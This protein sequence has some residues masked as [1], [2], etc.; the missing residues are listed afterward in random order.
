MLKWNIHTRICIRCRIELSIQ[1]RCGSGTRSRWLRDIPAPQK[2]C[3][4]ASTR[5]AT[6]RRR[7][8]ARG[9]RQCGA[10]APDPV[11]KGS[12]VP[13]GIPGPRP[14]EGSERTRHR[15][16]D[17]RAR[18]RASCPFRV[19]PPASLQ[20]ACPA[21]RSTGLPQLPSVRA[22]TITRASRRLQAP[23]RCLP[24][25][26]CLALLSLRKNVPTT[27]AAT[28]D[29]R[30]K[31][32]A[33]ASHQLKP[34]APPRAHRVPSLSDVSGGGAAEE[35]PCDGRLEDLRPKL[36]GHLHDHDAAAADRL[37][38]PQP[39][40][41][42]PPA[43]PLPLPTAPQ[44]EPPAAR[45]WN[46]RDRKR[47]PSARAAEAAAAS[48]SPATSPRDPASEKAL[49]DE[50]ASFAVALTAEEVEEDIYALTGARP[51]RRPRK[52]PRVVQR[53][54]DVRPNSPYYPA[55]FASS[56][57]FLSKTKINF[58]FVSTRYVSLSL[59]A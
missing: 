29:P 6:G 58:V 53:Q 8:R 54:L 47:R 30:A 31:P 38:L 34:W 13:A 15:H 20:R 52:R 16:T 11:Q 22:H 41:P 21:P 18:A 40:S 9:T 51:R 2:C 5:Q 59:S 23:L 4:V 37:L 19:Y 28:A 24:L 7:A 56:I 43:A 10:G 44:Q 27:M 25:S 49:S 50:R 57:L 55:P 46:L 45:P 14:P 39:P 42:E 26:V 3:A 48:L 36:M 12:P 32:P 1:V 35:E 33:A 17:G